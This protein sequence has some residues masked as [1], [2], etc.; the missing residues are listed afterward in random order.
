MIGGLIGSRAHFR[1]TWSRGVAISLVV[2]TAALLGGCQPLSTQRTID[3]DAEQVALVE[4]YEYPWGRVPDL[5]DHARIT[6]DEAG[7]EVIEELVAMFTDMPVTSLAADALDNV[8]GKQTLGVRYTLDDGRT[9][10]VTRIFISHHDVVVIWP[11]RSADHTEWGSPDL[12]AYYGQFGEADQ[13]DAL[14]RP[15]AELP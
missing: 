1:L 15:A 13:V 11:D 5:V 2:V 12:V 3:V 6:R 8:E 4:L 9:V 10:E 7:D 14:E